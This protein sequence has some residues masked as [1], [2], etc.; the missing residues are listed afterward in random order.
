MSYKLEQK[1]YESLYNQFYDFAED[2]SRQDLN[3]FYRD[4]MIENLKEKDFDYWFDCGW[5][6]CKKCN[7]NNGNCEC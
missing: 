1:D 3:E 7:E 5:L 2:M 6:P 4:T